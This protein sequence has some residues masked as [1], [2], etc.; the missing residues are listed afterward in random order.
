MPSELTTLLWTSRL[1]CILL[2]IGHCIEITF[3]P[4]SH[5]CQVHEDARDAL[6]P[7]MAEVDAHEPAGLAEDGPGQRPQAVLAQVKR[8]QVVQVV[9]RRRG[10][11]HDPELWEGKK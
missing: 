4:F 8:L 9:E 1:Y 6:Q 11:R 5:P 7:V 10:H 3:C 2:K